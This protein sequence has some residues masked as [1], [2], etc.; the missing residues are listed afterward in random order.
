MGRKRPRSHQIKVAFK[1]NV[2]W[3]GGFPFV[4]KRLIFLIYWLL[5]KESQEKIN[6]NRSTSMKSRYLL[7]KL[8]KTQ[9]N[10]VKPDKTDQLQLKPVNILLKL[11][12]TR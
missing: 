7:E 5:R 1:K 12:K 11:G 2:L 6:K 9:Y 4:I 3:E 10:S 8:G